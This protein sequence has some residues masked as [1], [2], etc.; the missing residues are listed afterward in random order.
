[1]S[2]IFRNTSKTLVE[3]MVRDRTCADQVTWKRFDDLY[4]PAM[5]R[6]V[7]WKRG[8]HHDDYEDIVMEV[9]ARLADAFRRGLYKP[10]EGVKFRSYLA[11]MLHN[12]ILMHHRADEAR[13]N[14]RFVEI[15]KVPDCR[16]VEPEVLYK[17][18]IDMRRAQH[19]I[20]EDRVLRSVMVSERDR[21]VYRALV[22]DDLPIEEVA[23]KF[24]LRKNTVSQ[25]KTRILRKIAAI[26]AEFED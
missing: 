3:K 4:R 7:E 5:L 20:A 9:M 12:Q 10:T 18:D 8:P 1:M 21:A 13:G 2:S 17:L 14:G 25:I 26:E 11:T 22:I 6:F 23:A 19:Q 15:D 16:T 24:G